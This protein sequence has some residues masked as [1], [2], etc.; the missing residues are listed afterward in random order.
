MDVKRYRAPLAAFDHEFK[1][2]VLASDFDRVTA[3]RDALQQLLN[4][5]D[6]EVERLRKELGEAKG[7]Y[8]RAANKVEEL[9]GI[10]RGLEQNLLTHSQLSASMRAQLAE[11]HA[12][13]REVLAGLWPSTPIAIKINAA[14]SASAEPSASTGVKDG[15]YCRIC[16]TKLCVTG[17]CTIYCPNRDCGVVG[18]G[19]KMLGKQELERLKAGL[20]VFENDAELATPALV[21]CDACPRSSGCVETCMKA[22]A[23]AEPS[24]PTP[25]PAYMEAACDKFDWTPEEALRF[26]AD[27]KHFDTDNGRTRILCTGAIASHALKGISKEYADLKGSEP[28]A[29]II[30]PINMKTI[31]QAYEQVDA[32]ALLHGTSNW[33]ASMATALRG[34]LQGQPSAPKCETCNGTGMVDD[35]EITCSEGGIPYE[36]GPVK[37]VKDCP[38]CMPSAPVEIDELTDDDI[39]EAMSEHLNAADGGYVVDTAREDVLK[40]GRALLALAAM[41]KKT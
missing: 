16:G 2:I 41:E 18:V 1:D 23:S 28:S 29:P 15:T 14:L 20:P 25:M 6:E 32:K 24:A 8:D 27:G 4:A 33:C 22:P 3:E 5:R 34:V 26:Y 38:A 31:M 17:V 7:E 35:G 10:I 9:R 36:N 30:H 12:L 21:E 11:A 13:L 39:I 19:T 37:C 40:A